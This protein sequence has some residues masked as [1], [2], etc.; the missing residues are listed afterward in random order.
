MVKKT[1]RGEK[2]VFVDDRMGWAREQVEKAVNGFGTQRIAAA[3][4]EVDGVL[5][6]VVADHD[7]LIQVEPGEGGAPPQATRLPM[8]EGK[9]VVSDLLNEAAEMARAAEKAEWKPAVEPPKE[10]EPNAAGK[11]T[12]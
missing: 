2:G 4:A 5:V 9:L 10:P 7:D 12:A 3:M 8:P 11:G 6:I 1:G